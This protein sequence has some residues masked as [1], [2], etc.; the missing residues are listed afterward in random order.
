M[1]LENFNCNYEYNERNMTILCNSSTSRKN[2]CDKTF[3]RLHVNCND[4]FGDALI[5]LRCIAC[6]SYLHLFQRPKRLWRTEDVQDKFFIKPEYQ[7]INCQLIFIR[8]ESGQ[9]NG[10]LTVNTFHLN[11]ILIAFTKFIMI[12]YIDI[13]LLIFRIARKLRVQE[14]SK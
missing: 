14:H 3:N 9:N 8:H 7:S 2:F 12:V 13:C 4:F 5:I 10:N 11:F 6:L 1:T